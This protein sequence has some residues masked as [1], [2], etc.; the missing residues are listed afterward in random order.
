MTDDDTDTNLLDDA[1]GV[2]ARA[3]ELE[4]TVG[5]EE[6][7]LM[8]A[9]SKYYEAVY[10]MKKYLNRLPIEPFSPRSDEASKTR[11]LIQEKCRHYE[12]HAQE[13]LQRI[14]SQQSEEGDRRSWVHKQDSSAPHDGASTF[15]SKAP[16]D[17][18]AEKAAA[19]ANVLA[20]ALD[21]D[22]KERYD[23]AIASYISAAELYLEAIRKSE[24]VAPLVPADSVGIK[25]IKRKLEGIMD[26]VEQL[27]KHPGKKER[28]VSQRASLSGSLTAEEISVLKRSSMIAS[29]LFMPWSDDEARTFDYDTPSGMPWSDPD[30]LLALSDK[31][32][33][34]LHKWARPN[35][36][37]ALRGQRRSSS[38]D[39]IKCITP[40]TIRQHCVQD[41]SFIASLC[42]CAEFERRFKRSLVTS[43]IYPQD[44]SGNPIINKSGKYMVKLWLNGVPRRVLVDDLFPVD[45]YG[46]L[47]V[48]HT[49]VNA[50][51]EL[52][53]SIIEKAY[54]RLCGGY[55]FPGSNSGVDMFSL[56]GWIPERIFFP[57]DPTGTS[58]RD[59]ECPAERAWERLY[60]AS[61]FGDA[62][63]TMSTSNDIPESRAEE[64]GLIT[65]H[66]YAVLS[67]VKTRNGTRLLQ[68]KNPWAHKGWKGRFSC[69]DQSSWSDPNLRAE[70]GYNPTTHGHMDDGVFW[71]SYEDVL[72]YFRNIHI[73]WNPSLF[74]Y[75][76]T[77]H[78]QWPR[79]IGP[80]DDSFNLGENPQYVLT[81]SD[82]ALE[83]GASCWILISR[84]VTKQEQ[85]GVDVTDYLTI[86]IHRNNRRKEKI[87]Y[88]GGSSSVFTGAYTNNC[89]VLVRY[90][91]K[92]ESDKYLSLILSQYKK[93]NDLSY[94]LSCY[95]T[96]SFQFG[97]PTKDP[98][99]SVCLRSEWTAQSAGGPPGSAEFGTNPMWSI[100]V[101]PNRFGKTFVRLTCTTSKT[102]AVNVML[103]PVDYAGKRV[104][105]VEKEPA[106]DTGDYRHGFVSSGL[107][108]VP[109]GHYTL[110][111]SSYYP[112]QMAKFTIKMMSTS[113]LKAMPIA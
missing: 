101:A 61:S 4:D 2:L 106:I 22:E 90:D 57:E 111:A 42:I 26:R 71:I 68:L 10:L 27:K 11:K 80:A 70:V 87:Y 73:S 29:G 35:E 45:K 78:A 64:V 41:C 46:N 34:R 100:S 15:A 112:G 65:G 72:I 98:P 62:L 63:I 86:H 56:T 49:K 102:M 14:G 38:L 1:F 28:E 93:S 37:L 113:K 47:L 3:I 5:G 108:F 12:K 6:E 54:M 84:H 32:K 103:I 83:K 69:F 59:F 81:L 23:K 60:S 110:V 79:N 96:A 75:R 105:W 95:C 21:H 16:T 82:E 25:A 104:R 43:L 24:G 99:H 13:L 109:E 40:Y 51:L 19:A 50:G 20:E 17:I 48:S 88:P 53:V 74:S 97:K 30:G 8:H 76:N 107:H 67:C 52:W 55:N 66:A 39:M 36:I 7:A 89:H 9:A 85:E 18:V 44:S 91:A 58:I 33:L 31:Q 94:T 77:I 92:G